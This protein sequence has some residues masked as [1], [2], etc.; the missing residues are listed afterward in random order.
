MNLS[1]IFLLYREF[2]MLRVLIKTWKNQSFKIPVNLNVYKNRLFLKF[3]IQLL[4][5]LSFVSSM[6]IK[7]SDLSF[8]NYLHAP[9]AHFMTRS[10]VFFLFICRNYSYILNRYNFYMI[11]KYLFAVCSVLFYSCVVYRFLILKLPNLLIFSFIVSAFCLRK[12]LQI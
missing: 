1:C 3:A 8:V 4:I 11:C 2:P 6:L 7:N 10:F 5:R 9:F 12:L